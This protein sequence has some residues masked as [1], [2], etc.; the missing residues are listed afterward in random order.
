MLYCKQT[1]PVSTQAGIQTGFHHFM[2]IGQ[3]F[4]SIN[5]FWVKGNFWVKKSDTNS[6][7]N[8]IQY[9]SICQFATLHWG[10]WNW[11]TSCL[12]DSKYLEITK[13][14]QNLNIFPRE[15][16]P[17]PPTDFR[18]TCH[19]EMVTSFLDPC[20]VYINNYLSLNGMQCMQRDTSICSFT[21]L[22]VLQAYSTW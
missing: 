20:L 22:Y 9:K 17:G 5:V 13:G 12:S 19:R 6:F 8:E 18:N 3:I 10:K 2:K 14:C 11:L 21:P 1:V 4:Y 15:H 16:A 7:K